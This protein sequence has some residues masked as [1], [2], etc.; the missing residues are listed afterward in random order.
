MP[1][2]FP[3]QHWSNRTNHRPLPAWTSAI[4]LRTKLLRA[5]AWQ[6]DSKPEELDEI[7]RRLLQLKIEAEGAQEGKKDARVERPGLN[8]IENDIAELQSQSG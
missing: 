4:D 3:P 5:C 6:V 7:D 2:L 8:T 1:R